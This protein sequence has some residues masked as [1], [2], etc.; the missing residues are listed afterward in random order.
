MPSTE[1][2]NYIARNA[3]GLEKR[4]GF[5]P[6]IQRPGLPNSTPRYGHFCPL[7][8]QRLPF[9]VRT[10]DPTLLPVGKEENKN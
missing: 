9:P 5:D 8:P 3:E 2:K 1:L 7:S 10:S 6:Q 4:V